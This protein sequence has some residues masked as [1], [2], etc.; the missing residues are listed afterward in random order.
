MAWH[1][2]GHARI[3]AR[4]PDAFGICSRCE[5]LFNLNALGWQFEWAGSQLQNKQIMVCRKCMDVPQQ[6][7]RTFIL[8]AD[9]V[10]VMNAQPPNYNAME[11]DYRVTQDD[12]F[13]TTQDGSFR[14]VQENGD[15]LEVPD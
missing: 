1:P 4:A 7:L 5:F 11:V 2:Y 14:V 15:D 8:S 10:P 9:P 13:R 6:Q 12:Q 3:N